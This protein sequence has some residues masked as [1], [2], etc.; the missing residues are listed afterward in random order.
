MLCVALASTAFH[1]VV[2]FGPPDS[3]WQ[4]RLMAVD[5]LFANGYGVVLACMIGVGRVAWLF[6]LPVVLLVAAAKL[7]RA[8]RIVSYAMFHGTWHLLSCAAMSQSIFYV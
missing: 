5:L 2:L 7:K 1:G 8:G 3:P 4:R 6:A